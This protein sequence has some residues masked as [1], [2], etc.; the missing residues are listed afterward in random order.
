MIK[1]CLQVLWFPTVDLAL[2]QLSVLICLQW[3]EQGPGLNA[4]MVR[5]GVHVTGLFPGTLVS[6]CWLALHQ[7]SVLICLQW[8]EQGPGLNAEM[9]R[10][11]VHFTG[12]CPS[13]LVSHCLLTL[14]KLSVLI[15]LSSV[16]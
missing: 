13:T 15:Y 7:L 5:G 8:D 14:H 16:G 1:A 2:H 4:E 12:L 11:G 6:H 3:D 10:G 9:V